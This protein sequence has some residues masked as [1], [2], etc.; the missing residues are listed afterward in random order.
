MEEKNAVA[1]DMKSLLPFHLGAVTP[2]LFYTAI[3]FTVCWLLHESLCLE[4]S[5]TDGNLLGYP[6][7]SARFATLIGN[8]KQLDDAAKFSLLKFC[9]RGKALFSIQRLAITS[10]IVR[11]E[12]TMDVMDSAFP[13]AVVDTGTYDFS[14]A[15]ISA[16]K[17]IT[18]HESI[19]DN[20]HQR[21]EKKCPY[22]NSLFHKAFQYNVYATPQQRCS[23]ARKL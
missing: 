17:R 1:T 21:F 13:S 18:L 9:L 16:R 10:D 14:F 15:A 2:L 3:F 19:R 20:K 7:L 11:K 22:C 12:A 23:Q 5:S 8:M 4:L 6:L